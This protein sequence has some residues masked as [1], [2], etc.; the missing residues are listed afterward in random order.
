LASKNGDFKWHMRGLVQLDAIQMQD[1]NS[2][3]TSIP[4]GALGQADSVTFRRLRFGA[5]GTMYETIDWVSEFDFALALQNIDQRDASAPALGLRSFPTGTGVQGGNTINV[6]QPTVVNMT[7]K[8]VPLFQNVR[9]G[10]Q[11]DWFSFEH[12]ESARFLDFMERAP[13]MDAF[14]GVNNN[15]YT[16]GISAFRNSENKKANLQ[17]GA[18]RNNV[19]DSGNTYDLGNN[20]Y[21]YNGRVTWTP[22]YD[23]PSNGRYLLHTGFGAEYR[24]FNQEPFANTDGTNIRIRS[25]GDVRNTSSVITPNLAD[26]GNFYAADQTVICPEVVLQY[27]RWMWQ[28]EYVGSFM[29]G[30]A[31]NQ[32]SA[33]INNVYFQG[34]YTEILCF[35]T[36]ENRDYNRTSGVFNRVVPYQNASFTRGAGLCS[37]GAWQVGVRYDW[38]NLNSGPIQGGDAQNMTF[39]VNWFLNPNARFQFNYV[40]SWIDNSAAATFPGTVGSLNGSRFVGHGAFDS[41][42]TRMDFNF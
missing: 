18:Y 39:G 15:G 29:G 27:G 26:T 40:H 23:E 42:G 31:P 7:F 37:A 9:V 22:W 41:F 21:T 5:E 12:I 38:L 28:S 24:S 10:N 34:G 35:L 25:R 13:I 8:E 4:G 1:P 6:I 17:I 19:Y 14:S 20:N 36:G 16:P 33:K 32:S 3:I 30:V 2:G 11:Q